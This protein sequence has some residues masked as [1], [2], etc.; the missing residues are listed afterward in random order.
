MGKFNITRG[1]GGLG[2]RQPSKDMVSG[3]MFGGI[4]PSGLA[5]DTTSTE[6]KRI[7]DAEDLGI[8]ESYDSSN[9]ILVWYHIKEFFRMNSSGS[10]YIRITAQATNTMT[11]MCDKDNTHVASLLKDAK[12]D[13]RQWG[14]VLNPLTTYTA[15]KTGGLDSDVALAVA[16]AQLLANSEFALKRPS[17]AVIEGRDFNGTA[18]SAADLRGLNSPDVHVTI[19]QDK[20]IAEGHAIH[21]AHAAVGTTLGA[22]SYASVH[23]NIGWPQKFNLSDT[24]TG[25]FVNPSFSSKKD[26]SDY[27][28][29]FDTLTTKGY[30]FGATYSGKAGVY[31]YDMPTCTVITSDYAWGNDRRVI[32]KAVRLAYDALFPRQNSPLFLDATT[33]QMDM[34]TAKSFEAD[35]EQGMDEMLQK[36]EIS[37][38][39]AFVDQTQDVRTEGK[40]FTKVAVVNIATGRTLEVEIGLTKNV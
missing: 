3:I 39:D 38:A 5:L 33:G 10:L 24:L 20:D 11:K 32:N 1:E 34:S 22:I 40:V 27:E 2:R 19:L 16:K 8:T 31:F 25:A 7:E 30:M 13:I 35:A 4:A 36:G 21:N 37:G 17:Q 28:A 9:N 14:V 29:D 12:G 6:L 23:E 18:A 15:T 26:V